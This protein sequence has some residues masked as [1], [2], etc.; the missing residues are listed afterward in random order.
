MT[1]DICVRDDHY[2]EHESQFFRNNKFVSFDHKRLEKSHEKKSKNVIL[3]V[4]S[5][6]HRDKRLKLRFYAILTLQIVER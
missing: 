1:F 2:I 3:S 5:V 4:R 6:Y